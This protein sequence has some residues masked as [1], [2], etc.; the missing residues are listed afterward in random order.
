[1]NMN[2]YILGS[3]MAFTLFSASCSKENIEPIGVETQA[4]EYE[5]I[6]LDVSSADSDEARVLLY[7]E[8]DSRETP[9]IKLFWGRDGDKVRVQTAIAKHDGND[10]VSIFNEALDWEVARGGTR[11][12]YKGKIGIPKED[13]V[14]VRKLTLTAF[15]GKE[16]KEF[17]FNK[18]NTFLPL[19]GE[20]QVNSVEADMPLVMDTFLERSSAN[21]NRFVNSPSPEDGKNVFQPYGDILAVTIRNNLDIPITPIRAK[22]DY[23]TSYML[24]SS[25]A[26]FEERSSDLLGLWLA[27]QGRFI[28]NGQRVPGT[29]E[30]S[31]NYDSFPSGA[32]IAAHATQRYFIWYP[33]YTNLGGNNTKFKF[34][35]L[36]PEAAQNYYVAKWP[37]LA[38]YD[39]GSS[40]FSESRTFHYV[41]DIGQP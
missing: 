9:K 31:Y 11:L 41:L 30:R 21:P 6:E 28:S 10:Y 15:A 13:L 19:N 22:H 24:V 23:T 39:L 3:L 38:L 32:S 36:E 33:D 17:E 2:K 12:V 20:G 1:M 14:G 25:V 18:W 7:N 29:R 4:K 34:E 35:F 8:D 16:G 5:Y 37:N 27:G 40:S 26:A